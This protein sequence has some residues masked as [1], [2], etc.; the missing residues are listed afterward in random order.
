MQKYNLQELVE[1]GEKPFLP[2]VLVNEPGYR[3]AFLNIRA[4]QSVPEH[5]AKA[6]LTIHAIS[7]HI[8]FHQDGV[9]VELKAGEVLWSEGNALHRIEAHEDSSLLIAATENRA[10]AEEEELD[11]RALAHFQRH[12]LVFARFD[13]L[14]V[15]DSFILVN[16]HDPIPLNR[17]L[18]AMRPGQLTWEYIERGP[19]IFRIRVQRVAPISGSEASPTGP[20]QSLWGIDSPR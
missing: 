19:Y 16:D 8:T 10:S 7:G 15:G 11:L 4:G 17:Q 3:L 9:P 1:Y 18:E 20:T 5:A 13:A 2:K 14:S 12:P 6:M